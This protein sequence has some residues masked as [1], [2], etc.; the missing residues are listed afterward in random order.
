M[1]TQQPGTPPP[2]RKPNDQIISYYT[3]RILIGATGI[4]LPLL[5]VIGKWISNG[6]PALE[7]SISD[8]YDNGAGGDVLVGVLFVLGFFLLSYKGPERIDNRA[9]DLGCV[10]ALGVALFPTTFCGDCWVHYLH[11]VF[12]LTLFGVFIFF[13]LVLFRKTDPRKQMTPEKKNRN[14]IY[15]VCGIIM[16]AC[17]LAIAFSLLVLKQETCEKYNLVYWFESIALASFGFSWI[18]KSE[19]FYLRDQ[20]SDNH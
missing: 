14:K 10:A 16:I 17:I 6:T 3:L 15:L 2:S 7:F 9:A 20:G 18:T 8:Y 13:S 11:F 12:A 1:P 5:V 19:T 4:L